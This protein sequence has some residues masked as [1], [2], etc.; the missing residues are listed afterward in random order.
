MERMILQC[1]QLVPPISE[2]HLIQNLS[3]HVPRDV[4]VAVMALGILEIP[5]FESLLYG[6]EN[7]NYNRGYEKSHNNNGGG[8]VHVKQ[9]EGAKE[10]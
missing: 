5:Q 7:I 6:Y 3:Q 4:D 1:R 8:Y 9:D 10:T 2:K